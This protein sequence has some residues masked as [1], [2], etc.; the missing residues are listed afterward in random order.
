L[1]KREIKFTAQV[2]PKDSQHIQ[3]NENRRTAGGGKKSSLTEFKRKEKAKVLGRSEGTRRNQN[4]NKTGR[5]NLGEGVG[6]KQQFAT[7]KHSKGGW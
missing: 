1:E 4:A 7:G 3:P 6:G 2:G 5:G